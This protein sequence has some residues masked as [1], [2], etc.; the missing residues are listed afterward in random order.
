MCTTDAVM[1]ESIGY[2]HQIVLSLPSSHRDGG[3]VTPKNYRA[4]RGAMVRWILGQDILDKRLLMIFKTE[5]VVDLLLDAMP[6][7]LT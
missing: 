4:E 6:N 5:I 7:P 2:V 1:N 3:L